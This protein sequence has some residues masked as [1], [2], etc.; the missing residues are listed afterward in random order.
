[1]MS[2]GDQILEMQFALREAVLSIMRADTCLAKASNVHQ[3]RQGA[4]LKQAF[5][6]LGATIDALNRARVAAW[7]LHGD[8]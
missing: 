5:D 7:E 4:H 1:M 3:V 6:A 8:K 2:R